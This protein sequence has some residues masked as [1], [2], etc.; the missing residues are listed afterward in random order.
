MYIS[1]LSLENFRS[2]K[3]KKTINFHEGINVIIGHNN[4]GKTTVIKASEY[5]V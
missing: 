3:E 1:N 5:I 4:A 2:F